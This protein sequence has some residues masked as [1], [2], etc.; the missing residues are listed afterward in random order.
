ML[1]RPYGSRFQSV[2]LN[3]DSKA[4]N[5]IGF[6]RDHQA[7]FDREEFL[8][9]H[10]RASEHA[11]TAEAEGWVHDEV[12]QEVLARLRAAVEAVLEQRG[13]DGIVVVE[14]DGA[15]YPK[16]R[17]ATSNKVVEG[18]NRLYF[19]VHV[20]PPLRLGVYRPNA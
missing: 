6:R 3:F 20:D 12:E 2:E 11:L 14:S 17:Q 1:L 9:G 13:D 15:D 18:E 7:A 10:T 8:A 5:E 19:K 16:T 4:L